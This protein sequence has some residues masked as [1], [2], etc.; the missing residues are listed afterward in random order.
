MSNLKGH[1]VVSKKEFKVF[2]QFS[3]IDEVIKQPW[4][5]SFFSITESTSCSQR[6]TRS[7]EQCLK[8]ERWQGPP[9][10]N[11]GRQYETVLSFR[12]SLFIQS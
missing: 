12:L 8:L 2:S 6:K 1:Y 9:H 5:Y 10:I 4:Q 3:I 11:K 7:P